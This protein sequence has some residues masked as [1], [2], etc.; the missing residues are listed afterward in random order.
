MLYD[1]CALVF[2]KC[3]DYDNVLRCEPVVL[4]LLVHVSLS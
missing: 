4:T 2:T 1:D 3:K